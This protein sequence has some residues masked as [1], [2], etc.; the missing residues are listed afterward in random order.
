MTG[1]KRSNKRPVIRWMDKILDENIFGRNNISFITSSGG[2]YKYI[3]RCIEIDPF[4]IEAKLNLSWYLHRDRFS[5]RYK[6]WGGNPFGTE[7]LI[8]DV[9]VKCH[10]IDSRNEWTRVSFEPFPV[11]YAKRAKSGSVGTHHSLSAT[12]QAYRISVLEYLSVFPWTL[13]Q[14][15]PRATHPGM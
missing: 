8:A 6:K 9:T 7:C 2:I 12:S 15:Y 13:L 10:N 1:P 3:F 4:P 5:R 11:L 14:I